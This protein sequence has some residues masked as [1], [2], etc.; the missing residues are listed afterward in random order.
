LLGSAGLRESQVNMRQPLRQ[1]L[2]YVLKRNMRCRK[3][4]AGSHGVGKHIENQFDNF[5]MDWL[6]V[7]LAM[8]GGKRW[9]HLRFYSMH[10]DNKT[11]QEGIRRDFA[12][13]R[14]LELSALQLQL[15]IS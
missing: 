10:L 12:N 2:R 15:V 5:M 4:E 11:T 6:A 9:D 7:R 13:N 1:P 14:D 3:L 8:V